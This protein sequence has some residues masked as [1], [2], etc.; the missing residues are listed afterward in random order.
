MAGL[1]TET[2][3][4]GEGVSAGGPGVPEGKP[5]GGWFCEYWWKKANWNQLLLLE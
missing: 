2:Q 1:A 5:G 4:F 3:T